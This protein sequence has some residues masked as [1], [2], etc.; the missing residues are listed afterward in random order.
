MFIKLGNVNVYRTNPSFWE[1]RNM[2]VFV[3]FDA[4]IFHNQDGG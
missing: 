2:D 1:R 3:R 4:P